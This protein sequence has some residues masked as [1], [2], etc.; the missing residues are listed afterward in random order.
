MWSKKQYIEG[1]T[2]NE[3]NYIVWVKAGKQRNGQR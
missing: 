1:Y 3:G 2:K